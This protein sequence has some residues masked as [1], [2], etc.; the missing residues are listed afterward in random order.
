MWIRGVQ[1]YNARP[2]L[3]TRAH[4]KINMDARRF[5]MGARGSCFPLLCPSAVTCVLRLLF[6]FLLAGIQIHK[7]RDDQ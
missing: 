5:S 7:A 1:E 6:C 3:C 4:L 2:F